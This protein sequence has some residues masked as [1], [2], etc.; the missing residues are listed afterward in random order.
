MLPIKQKNRIRRAWRN[1]RE[2]ASVVADITAE[3]FV[4]RVRLPYPHE[5]EYLITVGIL[6]GRM[7]NGNVEKFIAALESRLSDE[8]CNP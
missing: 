2:L 8:N 7:K 1:P 4:H 6:L 3:S 5:E